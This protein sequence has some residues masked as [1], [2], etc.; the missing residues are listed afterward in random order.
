M[1]RKAMT[2]LGTGSPPPRGPM[3][4]R[5]LT[6]DGHF[7]ARSRFEAGSLAGGFLSTILE[8]Q[9]DW[10]PRLTYVCWDSP[11]GSSPRRDACPAYKAKRKAPPLE[12]HLEVA[13]LQRVLPL[14]GVTQFSSESG[15][16][17]DIVATIARS[18]PGPHLLWSADKDLVQLVGPGVSLLRARPGGRENTRLID[19]T[20]IRQAEVRIQ[21]T[22]C[23]GLDAAGWLDL[24][25]LAGDG[26]DSVKGV[27]GIGAK[28]G[29]RL[30]KSM[31]TVVR[32]ILSGAR[33]R[34]W[35]EGECPDGGVLKIANHVWHHRDELVTS[36][37]LVQLYLVDLDDRPGAEDREAA[38]A[39]LL[40]HGMGW[41]AN[42]WNGAAG[43]E[44][45][46][47][48][49]SGSDGSG[50]ERIGPA[51]KEGSEAEG[52]GSEGNG[53]DRSGKEWPFEELRDGWAA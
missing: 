52:S 17:D 14:F 34:P 10:S 44:R 15:E 19:A 27:S 25:T 23:S 2:R 13:E 47:T 4:Y 1:L 43:S 30:L 38:H 33:Q 16:A 6:I 31:P 48:K 24:Q 50:T 36:R 28:K 29:L 39:W 21:G 53:G 41:L 40:E 12:F 5:C 49:G 35:D 26:C 32:D 8:L 3:S 9:R 42:K 20:N 11:T 45:N 37:A 22:P 18:Y 51:G 46:G 7:L